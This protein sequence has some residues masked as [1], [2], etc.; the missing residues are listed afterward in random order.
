MTPIA[1]PA[2]VTTLTEALDDFAS[3]FP[4]RPAAIDHG[5]PVSYARLARDSRRLAAWLAAQG[6]G[7]GDTVGVTIAE[8]WP[9]LVTTLAL[10][11]LGCRQASL[12]RRDPV[13]V[14]SALA[15][16]LGIGVVIGE[17][18]GD[19][20]GPVGVLLPDEDRIARDA[21]LD[22]VALPAAPAG[23]QLVFGSSGTTGRP[24]MMAV[25]EAM[26]L[27]QGRLLAPYGTV[28]HRQVPADINHGKR[29]Q[30]RGIA[31]GGTEVFA[32]SLDEGGLPGLFARFGVERAHF[33]PPRIDALLEEDG[34]RLAAALP[35][36]TRL[37]TTGGRVG[38]ALRERVR[39]AVAG[40]LYIHYGSTEAGS[41]TLATPRD[42]AAEPETVGPPLPGVRVVVVDDAGRPLPPGEA[43]L[44]RIRSPGAITGYLD[45]EAETRRVFV[46]GWFQPGDVGRFTAAGQLLLAGRND[47]MMN[48]G[49]IKIFPGE[50]EQAAAGFPGLVECAAFAQH[51]PPF[52]DIPILAVVAGPGFDA[53]A[54]QA[55]CR[56]ALGVRAPRQVRVVAALPRNP[57]GKVLRRELAAAARQEGT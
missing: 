47:E 25:S 36:T 44:L 32:N 38:L 8:D 31:V 23:G 56:A 50:I 12:P 5:R 7:P 24:K 20:L 34:G 29:L 45:D 40:G 30:L 41:V 11:R 14:R 49:A 33:T 15:R 35:A 2:A 39:A 9:Q 27:A 16:R 54:L 37:F 19:A 48:L 51:A 3:R 6:I 55:H 21:A 22:D 26:L 46:D 52:G 57:Q 42:Q 4:D 43:G 17:R 18:P 1:P 10:L 13:E 53:A 28:F